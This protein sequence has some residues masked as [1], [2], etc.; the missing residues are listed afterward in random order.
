MSFLKSVKMSLSSCSLSVGQMVLMKYASS[1]LRSRKFSGALLVMV[2]LNLWVEFHFKCLAGSD[3]LFFVFVFIP[4]YF[5]ITNCL[6]NITLGTRTIPLINDT[7][8]MVNLIL[9]WKQWL[10]FPLVPNNIKLEFFIVEIIQI[11]YKCFQKTFITW[12]KW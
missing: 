8:I 11:V 12:G 9:Y 10:H 3:L 1:T 2:H 5:S 4:S 7:T 6:S